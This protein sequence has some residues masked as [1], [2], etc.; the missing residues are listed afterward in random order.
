MN[1]GILECGPVP[2]AL[3]DTYISYPAMFAA[4]LAPLLPSAT[5]ET[6][7]VAQ[8]EALPD[9]MALDAWLLTGSRHGVYDD[10]PWIGPLK[11]FI[12]AAAALKRPMVGVC[13]GHQII[14]EA[15]G[16]RV[17]KAEIGWRVGMETYETHFDGAA[18]NVAMPAFHQDQ[19]IVQPPGS[20]IVAQSE[21][22]PYAALRYNDAP[23]LSVQFHP[24]FSRAYLSDLIDVLA[25]HDA[26]PGLPGDA[27][28]DDT[29][30]RWIA[31]FLAGR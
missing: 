27:T 6:V 24:E 19:V 28:M 8:G 18:R 4:Q 21:A 26:A 12:R 17:Q 14:A 10:L 15:L 2:A 13:F 16:G 25:K 3:R 9:P 7:A 29:G 23:I 22:C 31:D 1:I 11:D 20:E 5:F 30:M